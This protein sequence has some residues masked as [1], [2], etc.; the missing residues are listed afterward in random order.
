LKIVIRSWRL[1]TLGEIRSVSSL[2]DSVNN[3]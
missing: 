3:G 1:L 2:I